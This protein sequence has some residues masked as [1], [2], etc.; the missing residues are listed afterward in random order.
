MSRITVMKYLVSVIAQLLCA[1]NVSL[2]CSCQKKLVYPL[3]GLMKSFNRLVILIFNAI[4][5][6]IYTYFIILI[7]V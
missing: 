2:A 1:K 7:I 6:R 3:K 5:N 4:F